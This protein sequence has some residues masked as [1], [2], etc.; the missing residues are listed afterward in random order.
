MHTNSVIEAEQE[1][2]RLRLCQMLNPT[3]SID[4]RILDPNEAAALLSCNGN[5]ESFASRSRNQ[6]FHALFPDISPAELLCDDFSCGN[7]N[8]IYT[9]AWQ[10]E[11]LL[12]GRLYLTQRNV[13]FYSKI[14]WVY[15]VD[16]V[17]LQL[18]DYSLERCRIDRE[19]KRFRFW[20]IPQFNIHKNG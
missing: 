13:Y 10:R 11:V 15:R 5:S 2:L 20:D 17:T 7:S 1:G 6:D 8:I 18:V 16:Y 14:L 9:I 19:K 12:Q 4:R 3:D